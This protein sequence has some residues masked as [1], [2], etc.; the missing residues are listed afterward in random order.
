MTTEPYTVR[1]TAAQHRLLRDV[2]HWAAW[3]IRTE[4]DETVW[5]PIVPEDD[6]DE[7]VDTMQE[8]EAILNPPESLAGGTADAP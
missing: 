5:G 3:N 4:P 6:W 2:I 7:A 8:L 1:L